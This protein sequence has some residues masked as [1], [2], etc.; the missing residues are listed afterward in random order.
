MKSAFNLD[1]GGSPPR[2]RG[3]QCAAL[4]LKGCER[5][6]PACAG[7][8]LYLRLGRTRSSDHPRVCGENG[9]R[10]GWNKWNNGSP[11]R[12][13][14]KQLQVVEHREILRITPACAGKTQDQCREI[15]HDAD[16]PRVCGENP[17][18]LSS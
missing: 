17:V 18:L 7:K 16:H 12:V 2:V 5:I 3:K 13:R 15:Q 4:R 11:P 10:G 14:G 8:T 9:L 1:F 6:T